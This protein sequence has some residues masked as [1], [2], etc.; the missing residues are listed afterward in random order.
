[1]RSTSRGHFKHQAVPAISGH[2]TPRAAD[3]TPILGPLGRIDA[4]ADRRE[5][6]QHG[7][8]GD[9][10]LRRAIASGEDCGGRRRGLRDH[11]RGDPE[12]PRQMERR[13]V[14]WLGCYEAMSL[15]GGIGAV[16]RLRSTSRVSELI[17]ECDRDVDQKEHKHLRIA[18]DRCL[19]LLRRDLK[20]VAARH[21]EFYCDTAAERAWSAA[22]A[23]W[24]QTRISSTSERA[25]RTQS[26]TRKTSPL[27]VGVWVEIFDR[28]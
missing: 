15:L 10:A 19:D 8:S 24:A 21:H 23:S 17:A 4:P 28:V 1:M 22:G 27:S 7:S 18:I 5:A 20:P 26:R 2:F 9:A 3:L 6:A 14:A 11:A 13:V 12:Q 25:T 16:L